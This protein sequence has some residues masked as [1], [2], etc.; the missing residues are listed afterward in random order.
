MTRLALLFAFCATL[1][2][3]E[4][5]GTVE[6]KG[7]LG[8]TGFA[9]EGIVNHLQTG[10]SARI[11]VTKRFSV[12]PEFQYL[13]GSGSHYDLVVLPNVSWDF[14]GGGR[15]V[16]YLTGGVGWSQTVDRFGGTVYRYNQTFFQIGAGV[17]VRLNNRWYVAPEVRVGS[18]LHIRTSVAL[19]YTFPR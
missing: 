4:T 16:P 2:F 17:K 15:I 1:G 3:A 10:G 8:Y 7:S 9:D 18:E 13:K 19:G 11:Y 5:P 12:E 6:I 14:R